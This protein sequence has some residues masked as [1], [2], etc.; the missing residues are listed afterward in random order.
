MESKQWHKAQHDLVSISCLKA[1]WWHCKHVHC[2][3]GFIMGLPE[4][5][6]TGKFIPQLGHDVYLKK[7]KRKYFETLP[8]WDS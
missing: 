6:H 2:K 1:E 8:V 7:K 5:T 3:F 4:A